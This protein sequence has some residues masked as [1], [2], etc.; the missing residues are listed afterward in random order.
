MDLNKQQQN[1]RLHTKRI[2][3]NTHQ[4]MYIQTHQTTYKHTKHT[5]MQLDNGFLFVRE[6]SSVVS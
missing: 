5:N 6:N 3:T 2:H 4:H 1:H